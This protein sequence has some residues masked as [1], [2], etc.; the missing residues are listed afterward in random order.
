[1]IDKAK[2]VSHNPYLNDY[3]HCMD[4]VAM[5]SLGFR[6]FCAKMVSMQKKQRSEF[7]KSVPAKSYDKQDYE[8]IDR[9]NLN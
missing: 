8:S 3:T 9:L 4:I 7:A 6:R 5:Q 2:N 1:M